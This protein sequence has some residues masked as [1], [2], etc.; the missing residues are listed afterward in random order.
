MSKRLAIRLTQALALL[1]LGLLVQRTPVQAE[2][3]PECVRPC[4]YCP[5]SWW[6]ECWAYPEYCETY[7]CKMIGACLHSSGNYYRRCDCPPCIDK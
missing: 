5:V 4:E 6:G 2:D 3:W 7:G 1:V